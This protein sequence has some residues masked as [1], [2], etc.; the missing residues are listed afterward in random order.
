M[1]QILMTVMVC[2]LSASA[3]AGAAEDNAAQKVMQKGA[4]RCG[5]FVWPPYILKDPN[6]GKLSGINYD[7]MEK[8]GDQLDLKIEWTEEIGVG[9]AIEGLNSNRY[10]AMCATLWPDAARMKSAALTRP[11][12][13]SSVYAVARKDDKRFDGDLGKIND[14]NVRI[15]G[16]DGDVTYSLP[17]QKFP[18][19]A[20]SSLPQMGDAS[21]LLQSLVAGKTDI[22]LVDRGAFND[23]QKSNPGK[24]KLVE[25]VPPV[26][27]F[28]EVLAVKKGE[29]EFKLML[30]G[31]L[32]NLIDDG[33]LADFVKNYPDNHYFAPKTGWQD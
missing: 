17:Q 19:A 21:L 13:Y 31:A 7:V 16:V 29:M 9:E 11:A 1:K 20:L 32:Q 26:T 10:D 12:F 2:L 8:I 27:T 3:Y 30:D 33:T 28:P 5:Y 18:E 24:L 23:F 22:V 6:T 25:N 4:I 14:S 15:L